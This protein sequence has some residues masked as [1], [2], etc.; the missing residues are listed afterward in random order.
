MS[1]LEELKQ[2]DFYL[3]FFSCLLFGPVV[4]LSKIRG[5]MVKVVNAKFKSICFLYRLDIIDRQNISILILQIVIDT[6]DRSK[7]TYFH[8][9]D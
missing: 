6:Q 4:E 5:E 2:S 9:S 7:M 8:F 1:P 3:F